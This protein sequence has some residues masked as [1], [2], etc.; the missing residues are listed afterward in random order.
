MYK[1]LL[2]LILLNL[3]F[4]LTPALYAEEIGLGQIIQINTH[5]DGIVGQPQWL[6]V[7]RDLDHNI[8]IPYV[9]N[10][11]QADQFW[12]AFTRG[13]NYLILAS[14]LKI[15]RYW[16]RYNSYRTYEIPNFCN[17]ESRGHIW[18]G[19]SFYVRITGR[20]TPNTDTY[21]CTLTHYSG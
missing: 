16:Q 12:M 10:F 5:L 6:L 4:I 3:F 18:R 20:L 15:N 19:E 17:M 1:Q 21:T 13:R 7:I 14:T 11:E 2:S 9:Y 8:N